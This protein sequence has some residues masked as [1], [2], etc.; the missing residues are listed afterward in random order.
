MAFAGL[1]DT[2]KGADGQRVNSCSIITTEANGL[3]SPLHDRMPAILCPEEYGWWLDRAE[4]D[5]GEVSKLLRPYQA[6]MMRSHPVSKRVN[7]VR[8]DDELCA[9]SI[10]LPLALT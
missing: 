2:W 10:N 5:A 7:E 8:N 3:M 6:A 4:T 1:W 9:A